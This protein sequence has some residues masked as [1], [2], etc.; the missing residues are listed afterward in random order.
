VS[1][2]FFH[3]PLETYKGLYRFRPYLPPLAGEG[4]AGLLSLFLF[5]VHALTFERRSHRP[6]PPKVTSLTRSVL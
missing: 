1:D 6:C 5:P 3:I 4:H 2:C